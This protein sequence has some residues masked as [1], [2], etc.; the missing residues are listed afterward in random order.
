MRTCT[1]G[2]DSFAS[3]RIEALNGNSDQ[4]LPVLQQLSRPGSSRNH[5]SL[6]AGSSLAP[7]LEH[8][9]PPMSSAS[10]GSAGV[11]EEETGDALAPLSQTLQERTSR[12]FRALR[13]Q[14]GRRGAAGG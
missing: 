10:D 5:V 11:R 7:L 9:W 14:V 8:A 4:Q 13:K 6:E 12:E 3:A 2:Y 1:Q